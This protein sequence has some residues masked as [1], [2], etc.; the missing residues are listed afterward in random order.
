[1]NRVDTRDSD[2]PHSP[3]NNRPAET[4]EPPCCPYCAQSFP[5]RRLMTLHL[6]LEHDE[7][8]TASERTAFEE[9]YEAETTE[10]RVFRLKLLLAVIGVYFGLLFVY[11]FVT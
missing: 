10:L 6:G 9:A 1:M 5:N 7:R 2:H 4:H 3:P 8:L 11:A